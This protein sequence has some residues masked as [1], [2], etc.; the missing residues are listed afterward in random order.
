MTSARRPRGRARCASAETEAPPR[1]VHALCAP[2]ARARAGWP[3]RSLPSPAE[4]RPDDGQRGRSGG[5]RRRPLGPHTGRAPRRPRRRLSPQRSG[6]RAPP[7]AG[8]A[9][10]QPSASC[11]AGSAPTRGR[12]RAGARHRADGAGSGGAEIRAGRSR[13][14]QPTRSGAVGPHSARPQTAETCSSSATLKEEPQ[15]QAATTL[16]LLTLKPAPW[17]LSS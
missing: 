16:G 3:T 5:A 13:G 11:G 9:H 10:P 6:R 7:H 1:P 4:G 8:C 17:R 2:C 15:P 14:A 12:V